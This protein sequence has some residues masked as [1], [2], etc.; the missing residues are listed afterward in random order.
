ML[1]LSEGGSEVGVFFLQGIC[2]L[3]K[4]GAI[5]TVERF[6]EEGEEIFLG[7]FIGIGTKPFTEFIT[8]A[9]LPPTAG[10]LMPSVKLKGGVG[11][12][13]QKD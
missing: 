3:E 7:E 5:R 10:L 11:G 4:I 6:A 12:H 2:E 9:S 13:C 8:C 1:N